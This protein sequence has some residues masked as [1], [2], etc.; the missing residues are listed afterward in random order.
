MAQNMSDPW[1]DVGL[2]CRKSV[3]KDETVMVP[4]DKENFRP[5]ALRAT[6]CTWKDGAPHLFCDSTL[7]VWWRRMQQFGV[8]LSSK[9]SE[10]QD[11]Y[12]ARAIDVARSNGIR[13]VV[14]EKQFMHTTGPLAYENRG[15]GVIDMNSWDGYGLQKTN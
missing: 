6:Y 13:Y 15:Y 5:W 3:P 7:F 10:F 4:L 12:R 11:L 14:F 1:V 9:R 8:T 2:W